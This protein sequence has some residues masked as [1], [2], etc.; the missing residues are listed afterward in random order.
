MN[1]QTGPTEAFSCIVDNAGCQNNNYIIQDCQFIATLSDDA[2]AAEGSSATE[3]MMDLRGTNT[4]VTVKG[5]T[6]YTI[7][8]GAEARGGI[9]T[10]EVFLLE[11]KGNI[12]RF[13]ETAKQN[14]VSWAEKL[15][16]FDFADKDDENYWPLTFVA[17]VQLVYP[18]GDKYYGKYLRTIKSAFEDEKYGD[19][20]Q[21]TLLKDI[22]LDEN[23]T[24]PLTDGQY[25]IL[26]MSDYAVTKGDYSIALVP[27]T[28]VYSTKKTDIFSSANA[29]FKVVETEEDGGECSPVRVS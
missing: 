14:F 9:V 15:D 21:I 2:M 8:E 26:N 23:L 4:I 18:S 20:T 11:D 3:Q 29:D 13:D 28:T 6:T 25:F 17:Q 27:G 10:N 19:K 12:V 22:T 16:A 24:C 7:N 1:N 5:N